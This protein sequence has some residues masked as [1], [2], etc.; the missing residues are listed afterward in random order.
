MFS[1]VLWKALRTLRH[2]ARIT[3]FGRLLASLSG[4]ER[5]L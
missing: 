3:G 4:E 1:P 5:A 2:P